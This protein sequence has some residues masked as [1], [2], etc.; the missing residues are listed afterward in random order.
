MEW[1]RLICL[2][3]SMSD[4]SLAPVS[5]AP[6]CDAFWFHL[7]PGRDLHRPKPPLQFG[8]IHGVDQSSRLP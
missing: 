4:R 3:A 2:E 1:F 7:I 8:A 6:G 5:P